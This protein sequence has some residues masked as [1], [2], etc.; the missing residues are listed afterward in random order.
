MIFEII[1][2]PCIEIIINLYGTVDPIIAFHFK[3][4]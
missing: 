2:M 1:D 4:F 3:S